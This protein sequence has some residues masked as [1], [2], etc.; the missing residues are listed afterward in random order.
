MNDQFNSQSYWQQYPYAAPPTAYRPVLAEPAGRPRRHRATALG[1][2]ALGLAALAVSGVAAGTALRSGHQ[3][4]SGTGSMVQAQPANDNLPWYRGGSGSGGSGSGGS[5]SGGSGSGGSGGSGPAT[6]SGVATGAQERG[7]VDVDTVLGYQHAEAAGTGMVLTSSGEVLTNNHVVDG[8]TSISV[9]VVSTGR[10]YKATVVGTDPTQDV[11]VIQ[12]RNAGGLQ[13]ANVGNSSSVR[14]G[15]QVTGVGNAGGTGGTPSAAAGTIE[16]LDQSITASDE[17]GGNPEQLSGLIETD[18]AIV[19][20]DSGGPLYDSSGRI[21]GMD[22]AAGNV[23]GGASAGYAIT[24]DRALA[25][26]T[27]I[28]SGSS[29]ATVHLGYPGFL[30]VSVVDAA[31]AGASGAAIESVVPGGPAAAAGMVPGD[32]I[33]AVGSTPVTSG[34]GLRDALSGDRPGRSVSISWTDANGRA[35]QATVTLATGPAD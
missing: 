29:S 15:D 34:T 12:L 30:G 10:T 23:A 25:V 35:Q 20:G 32:V 14:V 4:V 6:T 22:T 3:V 26:A 18:A 33:T 8:A 1:V 27:Q 5:G 17:G 24:I 7:V 31:G 13:T 2:G 21:V 16:A 9:T 28:E 19:P 11:A